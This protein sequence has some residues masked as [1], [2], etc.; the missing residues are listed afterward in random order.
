MS[1]KHLVC[2]GAVCQ[3]K[4]G[5]TPDKLKV[6]QKGYYINET[7]ASKKAIANT[8]DVGQPFESNTFG[9]CKKMNNNP[10]KPAITKWQGFYEKVNLQNGGKPLL[11]DSKATCAVGGSPC[12]DIT[13]HGQTANVTKQQAEKGNED[14]QAQLN[15]LVNLKE[16]ENTILLIPENT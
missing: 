10:C 12:I 15:I 6:K 2:S 5:T 14:V 13:F 8:M 7:D 16:E 9:S 1:E 3:C 4:F 11:E